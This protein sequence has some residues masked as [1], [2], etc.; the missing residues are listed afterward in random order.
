[1][2]SQFW[3]DLQTEMQDPEFARAYATESIRI[4]T[5]D[6]LVN[7]LDSLREGASL[8]KAQLARAIGADPSV[9]RRLLSSS[10]VNPTLGTLAEVAAALGMK[11]TLAPMNQQEKKQ[12][13]APMLASVA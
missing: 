11:V 10:S 5:I 7:E 13:T 3:Q 1:M 2:S 12:I 6:A 8:S 9:V 4:A